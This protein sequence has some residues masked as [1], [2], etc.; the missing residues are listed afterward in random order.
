MGPPRPRPE[1]A[2]SA[3][4]AG[5]A[6]EGAATAEEFT[7]AGGVTVERRRLAA[8]GDAL[9][10]VAAALDERPGML[11]VSDTEYPG[12]YT[13][14][15]IGFADPPLRLTARG[16][17]VSLTA[18]NDRGRPLLG[19]LGPALRR[20]AGVAR[21]QGDDT[22][23]V[24]VVE[25]PAGGRAEES[26]SRRPSALSVVRVV[27]EVFHSPADRY[28]GLYGAFGYD[29][30]FQFEPA[31]P[32]LA[33]TA[34]QRDLVL[35][36]PD[37]LVVTDPAGGVAER[38]HY[39]FRSGAHTT[40]GL[41]RDGG[42]R[43]PWPPGEPGTGRSL[44]PGGYAALVRR[45]GEAFR[46]GDLFEVV[47][48]QT[49]SEAADRRPSE[50]LRR[51]RKDNPSPYGF[52]VSLGEHEHL[53]GTSPEMYIRVRGRRVETCPV[54][55]TA[56][57]GS[58]AIADA[59]QIRALLNSPKD[60]CE[61]T[62]CTDVDR[63]DKARICEPGSVRVIGR[64]QI[65]LY[66]RLI[67][68][69]D[70]VEGVLRE[71]F[72]GLD[73]LLAHTWAVTVTGAPK[74]WAMQFIEDHETSPR[75]WYGGAVGRVGFD[76][77]V[78]T[79]LTIR[80]VRMKSGRAEVRAGATLLFDSVP[81]QEEKETE[82]KA[83]ALLAALRG[84]GGR[85][86]GPARAAPRPPGSARPRRRRVVLAD[87]QDSFVHTLADYFRQTGADVRTLRAPLTHGELADERPGLLVLSPG[88]GRP[89]DFGTSETLSAAL[90]LRCPVFG[91]CLGLQAVVEHFGGSL[92]LLPEPVHGK[93]SW[94]N[95]VGGRLLGDL[96]R[97]FA[98]GRYHSIHA[99]AVPD[100][101]EVTAL[102]DEG[103]VMAVEHRSLPVAAVQF[104]PESIMTL[105]GGVGHRIV[106][107]VLRDL[108]DPVRRR[109]AAPHGAREE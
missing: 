49:F 83:S 106:E 4:S 59:E 105:R 50:L 25:E 1:A 39:D 95:V 90:R 56:P 72:D 80:T 30:G 64:R 97:R 47:L 55:G 54:S 5:S 73:A 109:G 27:R 94:I 53:V 14:W 2:G 70:H 38:R 89:A 78:D 93:T 37:V 20:A 13:R 74:A 61:L 16:R 23:L 62:M 91:V 45:A 48:S 87:H 3:G 17:R 8:G 102:T 29:L 34:D 108:D 35:Y 51:L 60:E 68:T 88:P 69:A 41:R 99:A 107:A 26:R 81:E 31:R 32:R 66:S 104:H 21:V 9:E 92:S 85:V 44:P 19:M 58:D 67:H 33:R 63:N 40:R 84:D 43:E 12:R 11:L 101:L 79:G 22:E 71:E 57:R 15:G 52:L 86:R 98:A 7:T 6:G 82:L 46:R 103:V 28:L 76:G 18:L 100:C 96:P 65:E 10:G 77:D 75:R 24:A 36:L 42:P